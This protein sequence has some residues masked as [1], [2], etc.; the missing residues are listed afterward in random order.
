MKYAKL[1]LAI[2]LL[3]IA[4]HT[5]SQN[6]KPNIILIL[7]DDLGYKALT[8]DGGNLYSTPNIDA[9]AKKGMRFT[10]CHASPKCS[11]SRFLL[12]TGKYNFRNYRS[13]GIM[14]RDQKT[15]GNM[16]KDAG[17]KTGVFGKWQLD[18]GDL[19]IHTFG[20]D[21]YCLWNVYSTGMLEG[22]TKYKNPEIFTHGAYLSNKSTLNKY[23]PD[24]F[25]DSLLRF[26]ENNESNPFFIFY[27]AILTHHPF[28]PTPDD[29][30]FAKWDPT[31]RSDTTFF[32][33][34]IHYMDKQV[35]QIINKIKSLGIEDNTV[36]IFTGDNGTSQAIIDYV[37][38]NDS[39]YF[40]GKTLTT[41]TGLRVPLI[42]CWPGKIKAGTE[43][44]DLV[45]FTDFLP[46]LAGIAGIPVPD[47][48]G[49][50]DG[51]SFAPRLF[52]Q[53]G[54]P[55]DWIFYHY[56]YHPGPNTT[57]MRWAQTK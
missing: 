2:V 24:I 54:T 29:S 38:E 46:T 19:S 48:Y 40:G 25:S 49:P 44:S 28:C 18:G 34:M 23:G 7:A 10:Q 9:L 42:V 45:D 17:Y 31:D 55:R 3:I 21:D 20:F 35:G 43:N 51:V 1:G 50:L 52:D 8:C 27:P 57:C 26:I 4:T 12:L 5:K 13:W 14:T 30:A 33:S 16:M 36:I 37:D 47:N 53:P 32:P 41:E 15:I 22:N 6:Q 11:P 39:A 56:D